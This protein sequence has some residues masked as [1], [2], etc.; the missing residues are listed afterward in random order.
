MKT[1]EE[2]GRE[3]QAGHNT[4]VTRMASSLDPKQVEIANHMGTV[5]LLMDI[6][7][8]LRMMVDMFQAG[9]P[10]SEVSKHK[11][12]SSGPLCAFCQQPMEALPELDDDDTGPV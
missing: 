1:R 4:V 6:G 7:A 2:Y 5:W 11:A 9:A 12:D 3:M 8:S 10:S